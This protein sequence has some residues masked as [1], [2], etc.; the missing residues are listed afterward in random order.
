MRRY[1]IIDIGSNSMHLLIVQIEEDGSYKII[2]E[3]KETVRLGEKANGANRISML[4][5]AYALDTLSFFN[6]LCQALQVDEII[7][8]ATEAVRKA[9]NKHEFITKAKE[10]IGLDIRIISGEEESYYGYFGVINTLDLADGLIM[11]IGGGSTELVLFR[12]K[13]LE[14]AVSLPFGTLTLTQRF[15]LNGKINDSTKMNLHTFLNDHFQKINWVSGDW[16]LIGIG[17]SFRNL[18]KIDRRQKKY[19]LEIT[20]N[21]PMD[22]A[23]VWKN[24]D[25]FAQLSLEQRSK[26]K[27]LSKERADI[28][29]AALA[30]MTVLLE[31]SGVKELFISGSGLR[32]GLF[33]ERLLTSREPLP[34]ILDHS[35]QNIMAHHH[36]DLSHA[37]QVWKLCSGLFECLHDELAC[38][39]NLKNV[40]K[41]AAL[42]HDCGITINYY[43][44]HMHSFYSILNSRINGLSHKELIMAALTASMHRKD[45]VRIAAPYQS[46]LSDTEIAAVQ[47]LGVLLRIAE[48]LDRRHN[49]NIT[50]IRCEYDHSQVTITVI[51]GTNANFE[52]TNALNAAP[53]FKKHFNRELIMD[54]IS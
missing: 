5:M 47:K 9:V 44:H 54:E 22:A 10:D 29:F 46:I 20:H 8:V 49:S 32:E 19:P 52:I 36:V 27:G 7:T 40:L 1:A 43:N 38:G 39:I 6:D 25:S 53:A 21:Y 15:G 11:D 16:P 28:F 18:G 24:Y 31:V 12:N 2:D 42:L 45:E 17:G 41:T 4:K 3:L 51:A 33:Y 37:Q 14:Q 35:L 48:N 23:T 50:E 13:Q 34:N 30:E 26:V